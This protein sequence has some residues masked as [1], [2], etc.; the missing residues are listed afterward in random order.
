MHFVS[1]KFSESPALARI[2]PFLAFVLLTAVQNQFGETG[3]YWV[4]AIKTAFAGLLLFLLRPYI[5]E[6]KWAISAD[7]VIAGV[8]VCVLWIGLDPWYRHLGAT[9]SP[10]NPGAAFGGNSLAAW[11]FIAVRI[12]GSTLIVPPIEE[13]FFRS[14]LYRSIAQ[15]NFLEMR[16]NEFRLPTFLVTSVLFGLEHHE[17]LAGI[18]AGITYQALVLRKNRLGDAITAHAITNLLLGVWIMWRGAWN[19]W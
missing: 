10:W 11:S 16:L 2:A 1:K 17:W 13:I 18:F 7:A 5:P 19:F 8:A 15:K 6:F 9:G 12:V 14:F 3:R 4:Y